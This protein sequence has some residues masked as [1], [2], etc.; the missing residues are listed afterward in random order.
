MHTP[1][2][3]SGDKGFPADPLPAP[4]AGGIPNS[5]LLPDPDE[6]LPLVDSGILEDLEEQLDGAEL[7]LRFARDYTAMWDQRFTRLALAVQ[8]QDR[9]SALDAIISLKI[10]SAMVGGV[11]LARLAEMLETVIRKG[12][13]GQGQAMMERVADHGDRTVSEL[14]ANYIL[15]NG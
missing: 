13:F 6:L 2:P 15:K 1:D 11:R 3:G 4:A 8:N 7:A 10:T 14:Q 12:D 9:A 5:G